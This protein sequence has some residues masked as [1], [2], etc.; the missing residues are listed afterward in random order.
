MNG[1]QN[2]GK[3]HIMYF[4]K[5]LKKVWNEK[6]SRDS[7]QHCWRNSDILKITWN[8]DNNNSVGC[9]SLPYKMKNC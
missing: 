6:F 9:V 8:A 4:M 2:G 7:I 3:P 1:I 5:M